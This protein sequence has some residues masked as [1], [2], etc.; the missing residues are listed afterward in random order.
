MMI[1]D[2]VAGWAWCRTI[3]RKRCTTATGTTT[4]AS[5]EAVRKAEIHLTREARTRADSSG[6]RAPSTSSSSCSVAFSTHAH[7]PACSLQSASSVSIAYSPIKSQAGCSSCRPDRTTAKAT[8]SIQRWAFCVFGCVCVW[9]CVC[10]GI[11]EGGLQRRQHISKAKARDCVN[12]IHAYLQSSC[13]VGR[14]RC[15]AETLLQ[16]EPRGLHTP[17]YILGVVGQRLQSH[18]HG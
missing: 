1:V 12:P 14:R 13:I 8:C 2:R 16:H 5:P 9:V 10:A 17:L 6:P 11:M 3:E 4:P 15:R 18:L 7:T